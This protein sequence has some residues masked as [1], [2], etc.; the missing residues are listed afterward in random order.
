MAQQNKTTLKTYFQTGD[1]PNSN[2]YGE[3]IDSNLNLSETALQTGE[4]SISSSGN[5][6]ILGSASFEGDITSSGDI[7]S[8]GAITCTTLNTGQGANEL[9][10]MNQNI[11]TTDIVTFAGI[12]FAK[13]TASTVQFGNFITNGQ[14]FTI[15]I[16]DL[17]E[18]EPLLYTDDI[19]RMTNSSI[20]P[21]SVITTTSTSPLLLHTFSIAGGFVDIRIQ[22][23]STSTFNGG[24][25]T[26]NFTII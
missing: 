6:K 7:K 14:S 4:F 18:I 22:N 3:F 21:G 10:A 5:F 9:Y 13:N 2:Q 8:S 20:S 1:T 25:S 17:P 19:I 23:L 24:N 16:T 15:T 12:N 26:F 11:Q